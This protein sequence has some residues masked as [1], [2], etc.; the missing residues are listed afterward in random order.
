MSR[1]NETTRNE[2]QHAFPRVVAALRGS[3]PESVKK[4]NG[5][6]VRY[7]AYAGRGTERRHRRI[8]RSFDDSGG[9]RGNR[10]V[11]VERR[12]QVVSERRRDE[13]PAQPGNDAYHAINEN[14]GRKAGAA[15]RC[16]CNSAS[17]S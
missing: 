16:R 14:A 7:G 17:R 1:S 11:A 12:E 8:G 4:R 3:E 15:A 13:P 2:A 10:D 9:C 6:R 5:K